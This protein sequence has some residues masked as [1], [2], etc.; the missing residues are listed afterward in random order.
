M[1]QDTQFPGQF[2]PLWKLEPGVQIFGGA[3]EILFSGRDETNDRPVWR[4]SPEGI[5]DGRLLLRAGILRTRCLQGPGFHSRKQKQTE[6]NK[7]GLE[8]LH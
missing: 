4:T 7:A 8:W 2:P 1:E 5:L 3:I 6:Q